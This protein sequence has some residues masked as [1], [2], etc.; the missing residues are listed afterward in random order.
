MSTSVV[1]V[2]IVGFGSKKCRL[3]SFLSVLSVSICFKYKR[4]RVKLSDKW[5]SGGEGG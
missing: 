5:C 3:S 4:N 2:G 1:F